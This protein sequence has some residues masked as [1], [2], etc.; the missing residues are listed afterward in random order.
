MTSPPSPPN[1]RRRRIVV[2]VVVLLLGL[3]WWFWPRVDQRFVGRWTLQGP[4]EQRTT[5]DLE[6]RRS[7]IV[8]I[9]DV[10]TA[11]RAFYMRWRVDRG[12]LTLGETDSPGHVATAIAGIWDR[13]TD[14]P[15]VIEDHVTFQIV[16]VGTDEI[17][18]KQP[19]NSDESRLVRKK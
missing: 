8:L 5:D 16:T 2:A 7:G 13:V 9:R 18:L 17:T 12:K 11:E 15:L 19:G 4:G 10:D 1:R 6:F 14:T 3:G